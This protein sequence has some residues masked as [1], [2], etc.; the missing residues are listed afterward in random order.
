MVVSDGR[1]PRSIGGLH[2]GRGPGSDLTEAASR[3]PGWAASPSCWMSCDARAS[4][5]ITHD[6]CGT[7]RPRRP[8]RKGAAGVRCDSAAEP[9]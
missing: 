2:G 8:C 6:P 5:G 7:A 9:V 3:P 1:A 4:I